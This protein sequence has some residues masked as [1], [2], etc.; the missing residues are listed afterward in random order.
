MSAAQFHK[1]EGS[2]FSYIR[3]FDWRLCKEKIIDTIQIIEAFQPQKT[4][5]KK[6]QASHLCFSFD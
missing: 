1:T 2:F 6:A 4:A 5:H 3:W